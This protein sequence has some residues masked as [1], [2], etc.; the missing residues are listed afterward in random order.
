MTQAALPNLGVSISLPPAQ[1]IA[2][3]KAKGL[4]ISWNWRDVWAQANRDAFTVAKLTQLDLLQ[5]IKD[6]LDA[7]LSGGTSYSDWK[8]DLKPQLIEA[9]WWGQRE[10]LQGNT[11]EITKVQLGSEERLR[12]IFLT[13]MQS[14]YAAGK[15]EDVQANKED[16]PYL[17]YRAVRDAKSRAAHSA[18]DGIILPVDHPFWLT[19]YPP[20]GFNCR[21]TV[22]A[23]TAA[24]AE[25]R[26]ISASPD[27]KET[28][29]TFKD[30]TTAP[31]TQYSFDQGKTWLKA[32]VGFGYNAG[33]D[34][35]LALNDLLARRLEGMAWLPAQTVDDVLNR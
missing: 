20:N 11:G 32:D 3:F 34:Q 27:T 19:N 5:T 2:Y 22:R 8:K 18:M 26:G 1:A 14:S 15:W 17:E 16:R 7:A 9:G 6:S 4:E 25:K 28:E 10:V 31:V 13:N 12:T 24:Q 23:L 33:I 30:G 35:G 29:H 21:C